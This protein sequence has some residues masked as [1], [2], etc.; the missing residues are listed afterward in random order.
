MATFGFILAQP[1]GPLVQ[2]HVTTSGDP[3][4]MVIEGIYVMRPGLCRVVTHD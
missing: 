1:V 2:E 4:N 3:G